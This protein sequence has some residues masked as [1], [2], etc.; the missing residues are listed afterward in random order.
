MSLHS[1]QLTFGAYKDGTPNAIFDGLNRVVVS[2]PTNREQD[3]RRGS[4][5]TPETI[6]ANARLYCAAPDLLAEL[7]E[8]R[9]RLATL[10][11]YDCAVFDQQP[12][13]TLR[14]ESYDKKLES[15]IEQAEGTT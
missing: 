14:P 9:R 12:H 8:A 7:K 4:P 5:S 13:G 11:V 2:F 6:L 3:T 15:L 1:T 10:R